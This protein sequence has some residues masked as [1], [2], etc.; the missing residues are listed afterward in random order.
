MFSTRNIERLAGILLVGS[1]VV[2]LAHLVAWGA[3]S[4][5]TLIFC[6]LATAS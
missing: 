2:F 1:F 4:A 5:R 6:L 3:G